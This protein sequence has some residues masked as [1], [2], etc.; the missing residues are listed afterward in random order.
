MKPL[1]FLSALLIAAVALVG[2]G[3]AGPGAPS[4]ALGLVTPDAHD[5]AVVGTW[6]LVHLTLNGKDRAPS[7]NQSWPT[8]TA[9]EVVVFTS[10]GDATDKYFKYSSGSFKLISATD[11]TW[12]TNAG[13]L[14][15]TPNGKSGLTVSYSV[16]GLVLTD[17]RTVGSD[18]YVRQWAKQ[19]PLTG[20]DPALVRFWKMTTV[21]LNGA[22]EPGDYFSGTSAYPKYARS[23]L[24]DGTSQQYYL[25]GTADMS[26]DLPKPAAQTWV[27]GGGLVKYISGDYQAAI[28]TL[29]SDTLTIYQLDNSGN[30]LT[31]VF[32]HYGATGT[33]AANVVGTWVPVSGTIDG[34]SASLKAIFAWP[35]GVTTETR[36][37]W[38]D[39]T[40]DLQYYSGS[41]LSYEYLE[42]W[43][44]SGDS[45]VL[46]EPE[47]PLDITYTFGA[48]D[49]TSTSSWTFDG[50]HEVALFDKNS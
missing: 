6:V 11:G 1:L 26:V 46:N 14:T 18:T 30:T 24:G 44:A 33:H 3:G 40:S 41:T 7:T 17:T 16:T 49:T 39:G 34:V 21:A 31:I 32:S 19:P 8:G 38:G 10:S 15:V 4:S 35:A 23:F 48:G 50:F 45:G 12:S 43:T 5:S 22:L 36:I 42:T 28:Y 29:V 25:G 20:H 27:S 9:R 47:G 2:C 13:K 37:N